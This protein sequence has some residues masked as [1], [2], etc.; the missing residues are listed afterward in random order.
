MINGALSQALPHRA[1]GAFSHWNNP[2]IGGTDPRTG[3][4]FVMYDL[5][6]AGYGARAQSDGPEA[7][8][9]VVNCRNIPV[10]VH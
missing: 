7:L 1:M 6:F 5:G 9:P 8:A 2:N 10:E 3:K 4:A